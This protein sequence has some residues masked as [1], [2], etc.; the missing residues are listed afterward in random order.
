[1]RAFLSLL[2]AG[3][4]T[5]AAPAFAASPVVSDTSTTTTV[6]LVRHAEKNPHPS[7]GDAGLTVQGLVRSYELARVA[8]DAGVKA[9][10]VS[11]YGRA[12][13]TGEPM[14]AAIGDTVHTYDAN[15]ND[16]LAERI[17]KEHAGSTVLVV[18]HGDS[19]P[20]VIESLTGERLRPNESIGYDRLF[21]LT[22]G[23]GNTHRLLRLRYG[24]KPG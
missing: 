14:A 3:V 24:A 7:G 2:V 20:M 22:L 17:R 9:V 13:L 11:Q 19:V 4:V 1:M 8:A 5:F 21:V 10:Y 18:G 12:R 15:R 16:L 23:P 6:I